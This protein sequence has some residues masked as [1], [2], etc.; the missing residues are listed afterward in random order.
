[1]RKTRMSWTGDRERHLHNATV[2]KPRGYLRQAV[3]IVGRG[4]NGCGSRSI[5]TL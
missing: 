4:H 5:C 1:V 3:Q 2:P